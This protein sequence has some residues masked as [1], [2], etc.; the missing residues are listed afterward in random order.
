MITLF[1]GS[2]VRIDKIDLT[3]GQRNK[4]FG[5]GFYL[6]DLYTQALAMAERKVSLLL[7]TNKQSFQPIVTA[8]E[9]DDSCLSNSDLTTLIFDSPSAKWAEFIA[10][11]R[12]SSRNG[13][14]HNYDIVY[15][16]VAND[17]VFDQLRRYQRGSITAEELAKELK[18]TKLNNQY[19]FG[20]AK[21]ISYLKKLD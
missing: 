12:M 17:G 20:T 21:A 3:K 6:T 14:S 18:Y 16:P 19:F 2:N 11:N 7:G 9:F 10:N 13:F 4:D 5:Q 15:G 1:H 8:F